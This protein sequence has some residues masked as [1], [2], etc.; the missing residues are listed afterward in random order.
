[1]LSVGFFNEALIQQ[2]RTILFYNEVQF[3]YEIKVN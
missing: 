3:I 2:S 1:M